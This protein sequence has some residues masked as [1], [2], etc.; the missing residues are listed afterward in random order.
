[1]SET[2]R[3]RSSRFEE[4]GIQSDVWRSPDQTVQTSSWNPPCGR[5]IACAV[6]LT[7]ALINVTNCVTLKM[8][9]PLL[10]FQS[11]ALQKRAGCCWDY[12]L[13]LKSDTDRR[14]LPVLC[15]IL[16]FLHLKRSRVAGSLF[17]LLKTRLPQSPP[18]KPLK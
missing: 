12:R 15:I 10:I 13:R 4:R 3:L 11:Q 1:M 16:S 8:G 18:A 6:E 2:R 9:V 17:T 14:S 5:L 7:T